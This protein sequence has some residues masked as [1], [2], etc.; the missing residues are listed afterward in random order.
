MFFEWLRLHP[1]KK[2]QMRPSRSGT[3]VLSIDTTVL[4]IYMAV[5]IMLCVGDMELQVAGDVLL[6]T[7]KVGIISGA[8]LCRLQVAGC[9]C[10]HVQ[11]APAGN[12]PG[13]VADFRMHGFVTD[14]FFCRCWKTSIHRLFRHGGP[15]VGSK[16]CCQ[17]V[18]KK[19]GRAMKE[20]RNELRAAANLFRGVRF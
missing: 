12:F 9:D 18:K 14:C 19:L 8:R 16:P 7:C 13:S 11:V 2:C 3:G 1:V 20:W 6:A 10:R 5:P 17:H 4:L 15:Y